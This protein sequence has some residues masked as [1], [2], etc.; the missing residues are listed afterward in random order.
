MKRRDNNEWLGIIIILLVL[1][2]LA[3]R[4]TVYEAKVSS[5]PNPSIEECNR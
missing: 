4:L 5:D 3:H 2:W 1:L